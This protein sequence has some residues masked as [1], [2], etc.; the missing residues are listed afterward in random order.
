MLA[1][2][3]QDFA[4]TILFAC[5]KYMKSDNL[6]KN[7]KQIWQNFR[8]NLNNPYWVVSL[9]IGVSILSFLAISYPGSLDNSR[10]ETQCKNQHESQY[11][12]CLEYVTECRTEVVFIRKKLASCFAKFRT[13]C[14]TP[15]Q[16]ASYSPDVKYDCDYDWEFF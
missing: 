4:I 16:K 15:R 10:L 7:L 6:R 13:E 1:W 9:I 11:D 8:K 5:I 2:Q 3:I 12:L 14:Y